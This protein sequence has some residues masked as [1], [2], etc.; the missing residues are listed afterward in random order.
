MIVHLPRPCFS[1]LDV[2][3]EFVVWPESPA[4]TLLRLPPFFSSEL[5]SP[6]LDG[7]WL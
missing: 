4:G 2:L 5:P 6:G 3:P 1:S 7:L